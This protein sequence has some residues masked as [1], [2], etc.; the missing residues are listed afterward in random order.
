M[1]NI[2]LL[3]FT[4]D[5]FRADNDASCTFCMS[6]QCHIDVRINDEKDNNEGTRR[7]RRNRK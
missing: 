3:L 2:K 6:S 4:C 1:F 5:N 7:S